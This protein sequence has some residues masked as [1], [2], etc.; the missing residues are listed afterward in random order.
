VRPTAGLTTR[1]A[2]RSGERGYH[3]VR[4]PGWFLF[5]GV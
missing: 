4:N 5:P 3:P 1:P 2:P